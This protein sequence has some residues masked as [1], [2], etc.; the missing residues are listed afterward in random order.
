MSPRKPARRGAGEGH[1]K[2]ITLRSGK[3]AWRGWLTVGYR[4]NGTPIRRTVQR[5]TRDEV[6]DELTRMREKYRIGLDLQAEAAMRLGALLDKWLAH[7]EATQEHKRRT[8]A[9][10]T[11]AINRAKAQLGDPLVARVTAIELQ[12]AIT[13]LG[14]TLKPKS[15]N[16]IRVVLAGAFRQA[17]L[18]R[19]RPDNPAD[20]LR[21]ARAAATDDEGAAADDRRTLSP[22]EARRL[23]QALLDERLGLAVAL[24]YAVGI[25][26]GEAAALRIED[27]DL[28]ENTITIAGSH[29]MVDGEVLREAPKSRRGR[30]TL[31]LP[32]ELRPW[33][34]RQIAR[35]RN[36]RQAMGARWPAPD[37]R[38]LFVR[39]T[40]GG[41]LSNHQLYTVA[42]R[43]AERAGLGK[44]GP[45]ILRR[46]MLSS[47][48]AAGVDPK[49]RAAIGGH[50]TAVTEKHYSDREGAP[51]EVGAALG[52]MAHALSSLSTAPPPEEA[53]Q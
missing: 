18:W 7:F 3:A 35:A 23:L 51:A 8:P 25:R 52:H 22:E 38:L 40:D 20:G 10:Y 53:E 39:E 36:E 42:R 46:S 34:E 33:V 14:A 16:V 21:L 9:T 43:V 50:T 26:P 45:R 15:V 13:A 32:A 29:N 49:V 28:E 1:V 4:P 41:R 11:W 30:R 27:I 44:V 5:H 48:E 47:L 37:E 2:K 24:T 12:D 6:R 31:P 19:I 17:Q